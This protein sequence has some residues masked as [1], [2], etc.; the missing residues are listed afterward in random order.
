MNSFKN[1]LAKADLIKQ[2]CQPFLQMTDLPLYRGQGSLL[3]FNIFEKA[4]V[5]Q[6]RKDRRPKDTPEYVQIAL[7]NWFF[8]NYGF[9]PRSQG[10]FCSGSG[11]EARV[12][13][14]LH[15]VFPVGKFEHL[16]MRPVG[17]VSPMRDSFRLTQDIKHAMYTQ[18]ANKAAEIVENTM[19]Q[20]ECHTDN[21]ELA[22]A[23]GAEITLICDE[24][25]LVPVALFASESKYAAFLRGLK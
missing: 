12:Y 9:K 16:W 17:Q 7:D 21:L 24:V 3:N 19:A 13:G 4:R 15:Y 14:K 5:E 22:I 23:G 1:W 20:Y 2:N 18:E 25:I 6:I 11:V 10:L 8:Q